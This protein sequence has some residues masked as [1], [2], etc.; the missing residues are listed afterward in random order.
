[1]HG[2]TNIMFIYR[3]LHVELLSQTALR[4]E[5]AY[6]FAIFLLPKQTQDWQFEHYRKSKWHI[7]VTAFFDGKLNFFFFFYKHQCYL[8]FTIDGSI[9]QFNVNLTSTSTE[10]KKR[11]QVDTV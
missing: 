4:M 11:L 10:A 5:T 8:N 3:P 9:S 2:T 1:M 6:D 7:S